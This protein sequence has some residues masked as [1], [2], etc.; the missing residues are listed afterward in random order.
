LEGK[1][2]VVWELV[3]CEGISE[4]RGAGNVALV[5]AVVFGERTD[6]PSINA[7]RCHVGALA[8]CDMNDNACAG[9]SE[10]ALVEVIDAIETGVGGKSWLATG[11]TQEIE[12]DIGLWHEEVPFSEGELGVACGNARTEMVL[13]GLDR[14]LS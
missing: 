10:G 11:R 8:G 2:N 13:P 12:R 14:T 3:G 5:A 4:T 7:M 9:R 1:R 6:I